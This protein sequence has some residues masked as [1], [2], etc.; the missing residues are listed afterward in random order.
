MSGLLL[1]THALIW[2]A[3]AEERLSPKARNAI[4]GAQPKTVFMSVVSLWEMAIKI[5][6]GKLRLG[7]PLEDFVQS[8]FDAGTQLLPLRVRHTVALA[9]LPR[10]HNDPFD[11]MLIVQAIV[12][13]MSF[14][15]ADAAAKDYRVRRVW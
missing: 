10:H 7:G 8:H 15:T 11:R 5:E 14:V 13:D 1:D 9:T 12:E 2:F 3:T 6:L 4:A